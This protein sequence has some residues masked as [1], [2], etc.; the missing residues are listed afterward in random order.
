MMIEQGD[1]FENIYDPAEHL[2]HTH[3]VLFSLTM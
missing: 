3:K 2:A 1:G